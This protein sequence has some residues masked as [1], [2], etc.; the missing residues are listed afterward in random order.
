MDGRDLG[1]RAG[2]SPAVSRR[3]VSADVTRRRDLAVPAPRAQ[4]RASRANGLVVLA[5]ALLAAQLEPAGR[6]A[7]AAI[8]FVLL[9]VHGESV[10]WITG[11]VDS[12]PALFYMAAFL[13]VRRWRDGGSRSRAAVRALAGD[14]VLRALHEADDHHDGRHA[15]GLGPVGRR[16]A[17]AVLAVGAGLPAVR[18]HDCGVPRAALRAVRAGR[19]RE[20][21]QRGGAR[22]LRALFQHHLAHVVVGRRTRGT[23]GV[24]RGRSSRCC[25]AWLLSGVCLARS[26]GALAALLLFFGPV[27]WV[28]GV[29]PTAVAGYESPRHVYL[30]AA[31]WALVLGIV[32][33][34]AWRQRPGLPARRVVAAAALAGVRLLRCPARRRRRRMEPYGRRVASGR[35]GR[36]ARSRWRRRRGR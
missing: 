14:A 11:R 13:G 17:A 22:L 10:A 33:D 9:P 1:T 21:A 25:A 29:A 24:G 2:R 32:A 5:I 6:D 28:I 23:A 26:A 19:A 31:G 16:M 8:V 3:V 18:A 34:L 30:A 35:A 12:M 27:W 4:H 15:G 20:P 7:G 36:A